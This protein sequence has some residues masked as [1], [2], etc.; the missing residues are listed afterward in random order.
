MAGRFPMS[1]QFDAVGHEQVDISGLNVQDVQ[2]WVLPDPGRAYIVDI[3][4]GGDEFNRRVFEVTS[5]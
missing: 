1:A 3:E 2:W 5:D 4:S